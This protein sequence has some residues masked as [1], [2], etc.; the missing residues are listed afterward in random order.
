M[1]RYGWYLE[2]QSENFPIHSSSVAET[3]HEIEIEEGKCFGEEYLRPPKEID[4]RR[5][6]SIKASRGF[7]GCFGY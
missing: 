5:I 2:A 6:L 1:L 3:L 4:L 7:T